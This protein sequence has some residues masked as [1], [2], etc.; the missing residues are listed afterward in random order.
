[1]PV[2]FTP[3]QLEDSVRDIL[4]GRTDRDSQLIDYINLAQ[5][6]ICRMYDWIELSTT[7]EISPTYTGTVATDRFF[8][9]SNMT[10]KNPKKIYSVIVIDGASSRKLIRKS[11]AQWDEVA[12]QPE[13][14]SRKGR[15]SHYVLWQDK[16]E[17]WPIPETSRKFDVRLMK[18]ATNLTAGVTS[19]S[20]DL[21]EKDDAIIYLAAGM[22]FNSLGEYEKGKMFT[23]FGTSLLG[24]SIDEE[25]R[26]PGLLI[27][28]L[29]DDEPLVGD[30]WKDPFVSRNP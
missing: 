8:A 12:P 7:E 13:A 15:P 16:I 18:W 22:A 5:Q 4:A 17:W 25:A 20:S 30:Y 27:K 1:V 9:L 28:P 14:T 23:G 6:R 11:P 24:E 19:G 26:E 21:K 10:N 2:A 3:K 29:A